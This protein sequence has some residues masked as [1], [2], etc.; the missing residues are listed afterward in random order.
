[1]FLHIFYCYMCA[2]GINFKF[3]NECGRVL[4]DLVKI[5][6]PVFFIRRGKKKI[7]EEIVLKKGRKK[8]FY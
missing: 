4:Q 6:H 8:F 1:L 2:G 7:A 5:I 3:K